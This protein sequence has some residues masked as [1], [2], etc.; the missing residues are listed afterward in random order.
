MH[1]EKSQLGTR[2]RRIYSART[3]KGHMFS[4]YDI[5]HRKIEKRYDIEIKVYT[6]YSMLKMLKSQDKHNEGICINYACQ[7][8]SF[9]RKV[10]YSIW[11]VFNLPLRMCTC[12]VRIKL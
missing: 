5:Y 11:F 3:K 4:V 12:R 1:K 6:V 8:F 9:G 2:D 10:T 7:K